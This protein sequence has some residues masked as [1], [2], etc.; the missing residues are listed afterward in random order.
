MFE[1]PYELCYCHRLT[2]LHINYQR[3]VQIPV[4][5]KGVRL[6]GGYEA[7][8]VVEDRE[9]KAVEQLLPVHEAQLLTYLK[10]SGKRVGSLFN[11]NVAVLKD[12]IIRR[13]L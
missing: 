1:K 2:E 3:Q 11:F 10:F 6:E 9:I 12:G 7:A 8:L 13:V 5:Y 4:V